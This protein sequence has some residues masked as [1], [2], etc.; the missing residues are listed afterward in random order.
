M[1]KLLFKPFV[2]WFN[3]FLLPLFKQSPHEII[4]H[5]FIILI[6]SPII[7][8]RFFMSGICN[9]GQLSLGTPLFLNSPR[10]D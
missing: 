10:Y 1:V 7:Y 4:I 3:P 2:D 8:F 9:V 5:P 6:D